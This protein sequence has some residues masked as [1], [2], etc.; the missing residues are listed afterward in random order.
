MKYLNKMLLVISISVV[1]SGGPLG[2]GVLRALELLY[3][4]SVC[5]SS[6]QHL[7]STKAGG[8]GDEE[9]IYFVQER[10]RHPTPYSNHPIP[11]RTLHSEGMCFI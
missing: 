8:E 10:L 9:G 7:G 4:R 2:R 1:N 5:V 6:S 11:Y 3:G